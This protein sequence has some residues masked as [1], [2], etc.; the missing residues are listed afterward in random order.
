MKYYVIENSKTTFI[1]KKNNEL[2]EKTQKGS[3][4]SSENNL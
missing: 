1:K 3:L 2:Q 4:I